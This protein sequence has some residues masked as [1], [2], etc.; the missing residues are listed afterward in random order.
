MLNVTI[1]L[2]FAGTLIG[3]LAAIAMMLSSNGA[4]ILS[5]LAGQGGLAPVADDAVAAPRHAA[6]RA[7]RFRPVVRADRPALRAAA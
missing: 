5:A 1:S 2:L 3:S 4:R 6:G 7:N